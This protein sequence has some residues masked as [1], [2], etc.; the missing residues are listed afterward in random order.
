ML[1]SN[2]ILNQT[3]RPVLEKGLDAA[4]LRQKAIADNLANLTTPGYKRIEVKFEDTLREALNREA[5]RGRKTDDGHQS[6]GR[7]DLLEVFPKAYRTEDTTLPG[8][9]NSVDVDLEMAK[10]AENQIN[11]NYQVKF[12][13]NMHENFFKSISEGSGS[14]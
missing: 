8:Q 10:L 12:L 9:T 7:P 4:A 6:I 5:H 14:N 3:E 2:A 11:Y 13:Q 1:L